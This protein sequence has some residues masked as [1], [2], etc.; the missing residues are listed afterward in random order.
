MGAYL[1]LK[2]A[3]AIG[4]NL[5]ARPTRQQKKDVLNKELVDHE[6]LKTVTFDLSEGSASGSNA[7]D[8]DDGG[9][10]DRPRQ[11]LT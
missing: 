2:K 6:N 11:G 5:L 10:P 7:Q 9:D 1:Y 8:R 4:D 3:S